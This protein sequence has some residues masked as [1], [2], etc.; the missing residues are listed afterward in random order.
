M[1]RNREQGT[2]KYWREFT[3]NTAESPKRLPY[4]AGW[5]DRQERREEVKEGGWEEKHPRDSKRE[6]T[7]WDSTQKQKVHPQSWVRLQGGVQGKK[8]VQTMN[9]KVYYT[10]VRDPILR[11]FQ[12]RMSKCADAENLCSHCG[13]KSLKVWNVEKKK[14]PMWRSQ[15][16]GIGRGPAS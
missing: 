15:T 11:L 2:W 6:V 9:F 12:T 4:F 1:D 5:E 10:L 3:E 13:G 16:G 7:G 14:E 8:E